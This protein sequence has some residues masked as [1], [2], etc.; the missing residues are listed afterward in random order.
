MATSLRDYLGLSEEYWARLSEKDR[1][2]Y[3]LVR[4]MPSSNYSI[5]VEVRGVQ[6]WL[7]GQA[8]DLASAGGALEL[9]PDFQ[10]GHVWTPEQQTA[11]VESMMRGQAE[12]RI[13]FNCPDYGRG[14][15][16]GGDIPRFLMQCIDGLQRLTALQRFARDDLPVFGGR[17]MSDFNGG[18]F[19]ARRMSMVVRVFAFASRA[20]VLRFYLQ[21]NSGGTV[22]TASELDKV[23]ALLRAEEA[24]AGP[25][26]PSPVAPRRAQRKHRC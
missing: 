13:L 16:A 6:R 2:M 19:D 23:R 22:H 15:G 5:N 12:A 11:F 17:V 18:P 25:A 21:I 10:R 1:T 20:D 8:S 9:D 26:S 14:E 3:D 7:D 24:V 4:P